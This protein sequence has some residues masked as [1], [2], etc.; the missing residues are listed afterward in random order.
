[1]F[2]KSMRWLDFRDFAKF[3]LLLLTKH[4]WRLWTQPN[5]LLAYILKVCYFPHTDYLSSGLGS[6][7]SL[8]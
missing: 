8:T 6:Y 3:N 5:C 1:M 4:S 2:A 7:P